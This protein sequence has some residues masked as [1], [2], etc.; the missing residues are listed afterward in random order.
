MRN[1]PANETVTKKQDNPLAGT[2]TRKRV[3]KVPPQ[4]IQT[5]PTEAKQKNTEEA[6]GLNAKSDV[7]E[8]GE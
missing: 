2:R 1:K 4:P 8:R 5:K 7:F 3:F 6:F